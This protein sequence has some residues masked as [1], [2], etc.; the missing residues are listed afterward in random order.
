MRIVVLTDVH[1]NLPAL[2][3]ALHAIE[4]EGYDLL[5]HL[6]DVIAIGPF[7]AECLERLLALPRAR[8]LMGNHDAWF[9]YGLPE[10]RPSWMSEGELEHQRWT[11]A[12]LDPALR[13]TV[14]A[15][16]DLIEEEYGGV[17][18][19]LLHY[20]LSGPRSFVPIIRE[21]SAADLDQLFAG[22]WA[23]LICYGHHHPFSDVQGRARYL[24]SGSL[25]CA[26]TAVA[27]YSVLELVGRQLRL[28]HQ[29][30][31]Y[32]D[33]PLAAAFVARAVPER[34]FINAAF[35]GGRLGV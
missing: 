20:S 17:R 4:R 14:G 21:P 27:R 25:G 18:L 16:P 22:Y 29:S 12:Q 7:P 5:V 3:V 24:N 6:G 15:W 34:T 2:N 13:S 28:T 8:L 11:H 26:P 33:R 9:A 30:I 1:G 35:F 32:D 31:P 19:T 23:D 10:P